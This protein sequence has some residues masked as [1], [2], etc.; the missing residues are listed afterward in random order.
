MWV[1]LNV[2]LVHLKKKNKLGAP[3]QNVSMEPW[4]IQLVPVLHQ[5]LFH[6]SH[7]CN[8]MH[9]HGVYQRF[10][11]NW[12]VF[13]YTALTWIQHTSRVYMDTFDPISNRNRSIPIMQSEC[14]TIYVIYKSGKHMFV[15]TYSLSRAPDISGLAAHFYAFDFNESPVG[16]S[17]S[18]PAPS[19]KK[20][21]SI[22][23][24]VFRSVFINTQ[25]RF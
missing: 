9:Q 24:S 1:H 25:G 11:T 15:C 14:P 4:P 19:I 8:F 18:L 20:K 2:L 21:D 23:T 13:K 5:G 17:F 16:E 22:A 6:C 12:N 7:K 3:M 10:S